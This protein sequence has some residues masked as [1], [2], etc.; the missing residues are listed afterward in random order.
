MDR[1]KILAAPNSNRCT[2]AAAFFTQLSTW[3]NYL[4]VSYVFI[5]PHHLHHD[6]SKYYGN[7]H[8]HELRSELT[9][10]RLIWVMKRRL[11]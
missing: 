4:Y 5:R 7:Y 1:T 10:S 9:S 8:R 6:Y 11:A 3:L 2:P